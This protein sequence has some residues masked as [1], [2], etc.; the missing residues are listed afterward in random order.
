MPLHSKIHRGADIGKNLPTGKIRSLFNLYQAER[1][2]TNN[3]DDL[4]LISVIAEGNFGGLSDWII[5]LSAQPDGDYVFH[6]FGNEIAGALGYS[7]LGRL[8]STG[9]GRPYDFFKKCFDLIRETHEP[10]LTE[11]SAVL[12]PS[13]ASWTR[14]LLPCY[15]DTR[16]LKIVGALHP[17]SWQECMLESLLRISD[18]PLIAIK[19]VRNQGRDVIDA[20]IVNLNDLAR[21]VLNISAKRHLYLSKCAPILLSAELLPTIKS[22]Y[23][24]DAKV[25]IQQ[26]FEINGVAFSGMTATHCG[27]GAI[28]ELNQPSEHALVQWENVVESE[29]G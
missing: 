8:V 3:R 26:S 11:N 18:N 5:Q 21:R 13:V 14:L 4:P 28:L 10:L 15:D 27:D 12:T 24:N 25:R 22:A 19:M 23:A 29:A 16:T 1:A 9:P 20:E 2:S 7:M 6:S 17:V